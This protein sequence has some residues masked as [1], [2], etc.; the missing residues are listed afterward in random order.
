M[1][2]KSKNFLKI[3]PIEWDFEEKY[4]IDKTKPPKPIQLKDASGPPIHELSDERNYEFLNKL[5][6]M[7]ELDPFAKEAY[8]VNAVY[9]L[10][11]PKG[12]TSSTKGFNVP[13]G[14]SG[15]TSKYMSG[16]P[17]W[18]E[19]FKKHGPRKFY[20]DKDLAKEE[21]GTG[22]DIKETGVVG[23]LEDGWNTERGLHT[24]LHEFRHKAFGD[25]PDYRKV[26]K[27]TRIAP[28]R[29]TTGQSYDKEEIIV[30]AFDAIYFKEPRAIELLKKM[31]LSK[32]EFNELNQAVR[33]LTKLVEA[34]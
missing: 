13:K 33:D 27:D 17:E 7:K 10:M 24:L 34:K 5:F 28:K 1:A 8:D 15:S 18:L 22:R 9:Q 23:I 19:D 14:Y 30:R 2:D 11:D 12:K 21:R 16:I 6:E 31:K 3:P 20:K 32:R 4:K 25:N 29:F 26:I